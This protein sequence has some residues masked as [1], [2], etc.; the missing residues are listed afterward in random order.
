[1][2]EVRL[3]G[4]DGAQVGIAPIEQALQAARE[5]Q[6]DLVEI[7]P[8]AKPPVCRLL[9]F[10]KYVYEQNKKTKQ[11]K[12]R[13]K[14]VHVKEVKLKPKIGE[15][16]YQVKLH[17]VERFLKRGDLVKLTLMFRGREVVHPELGQRIMGRLTEDLQ[18]IG[19][20][21]RSP[22]MEGRFLTMVVAPK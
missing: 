10:A 14:R 21:E 22:M 2:K 4:A 6:V 19:R 12:K 7:A 13:Q 1:M 17:H 3:I 18:E 9:D 20:V 15:H 11:A 16:D 8:D 5:A